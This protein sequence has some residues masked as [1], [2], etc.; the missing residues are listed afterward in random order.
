MKKVFWL[1]IIAT[2]I[3]TAAQ[4][5]YKT[6]AD[7]LPQ[8][9]WQIPFAVILMGVVMLLM[10]L[11]LKKAELSY[12]YPIMATSFIWV[13]LLGYLVLGEQL[14]TVNWA[15]LTLIFLGVVMIK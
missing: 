9:S 2:I 3:A 11:A 15:G 5:F 1:V 12:A 7:K 4:Y 10:V 13:G 8:L 14:S 6:G